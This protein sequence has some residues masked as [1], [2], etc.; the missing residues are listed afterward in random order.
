M[1]EVSRKSCRKEWRQPKLQKLP[2]AAT[3]GGGFDKDLGNEG[4]GQGKGEGG[5]P[6]QS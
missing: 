5:L 4:S 6:A 3:A 1:S 2:I